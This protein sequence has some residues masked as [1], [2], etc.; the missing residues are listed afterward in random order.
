[1]NAIKQLALV[2]FGVTEIDDGE[3][4][5]NCQEN[6]HSFS[7]RAEKTSQ[8]TSKKL[9]ADADGGMGLR[10][11]DRTKVFVRQIDGSDRER[12]CKQ[13]GYRRRND[14]FKRNYFAGHR[15]SSL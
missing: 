15:G 9:V 1:L 5:Q 6:S 3:S 4:D 12:D 10:L 7:L 13:G 11:F 8:S 14:E 2:V